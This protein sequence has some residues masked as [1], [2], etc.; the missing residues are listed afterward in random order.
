MNTG[1]PENEW[2]KLF[3]QLPLDATAGDEHRRQLREKVLAV[4]DAQ[5]AR[6]SQF[7]GLNRLGHIL[8]TYKA[9]HWTAAAILIA[10]IA[11]IVHSSDSPA[12]AFNALVDN[13][14]QA[15]TARYEMT[16][17]IVGQP[18]RK[19]K[20]YYAEPSHF[21]QEIENGF[22]NIVD[23]N[24]GKMVGLDSTAKRATVINLV[25]VE[26]DQKEK[27]QENHFE[28]I[29]TTLRDAKENPETNVESLGE[30][31]FD[32]R[33]TVGF[34]LKVHTYPMTIWADP[35]TNLPVRIEAT[36][37]GPPRTNV[38]MTN[39]EFNIDLDNSLFSVTIP[40]DYEVVETDVDASPPV[41]QDFITALQMCCDVTDGEFP[42][43]LDAGSIAKYVA[44]YF[45][46]KGVKKEPTA[47][48]M[49]EAFKIGRGF[50]FALT[51]PE[52]SNAHYAGAGVKQN[53]A[54]RPVFFY[55][56]PDKETYR[57]IYADLSVKELD[58]A[59]TVSGAV[60]VSR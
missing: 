11:W 23:W 46:K 33:Q 31:E 9:P 27:M 25:N 43:G 20:A 60:K 36:M 13:V 2:E 5:S 56:P 38:V 50:Q 49:Q 30:R 58:Q 41:E 37:V 40:D 48:E 15:R 17:T 19:M 29:R 39:Y 3:E 53:D 16:A 57:V 32:G 34:R 59:P 8:M 51:L 47:A 4:F 14:M 26:E 28:M 54:T 44:T 42:T 7:L 6:H 10:C 18:P 52:E 55:I 45:A 21:R 12:F 1:R 35:Q 22:V 24:V